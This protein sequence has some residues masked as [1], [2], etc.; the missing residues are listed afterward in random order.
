MKDSFSML[1]T[2]TMSE[3]LI[4]F[5]Q[6]FYKQHD[7][8]PVG[9]PLGPKPV[10]VFLYHE[11]IW[12]QNCSSEFKIGICRRYV[13]DIFLLFRLKHNIKKFW[14]YQMHQHE[15]IRFTS[16]TENKNSIF[17]L[18]IKKSWD[19][20]KFRTSVNCKPKVL[21]TLTAPS[22]SHK[23]NL[24][25]ILLHREFK[26]CSSFRLFH[27]EIDKLRI[28]FKNS[29]YPKSFVDLCVKKILT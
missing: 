4:L 3:S 23:H 29:G 11:K 12:L 9:T 8:V 19:S 1:L 28:I 25:F 6:E 22:Q 24:L 14:N 15:N 10:N 21:P 27:Q 26:Q 20:N 18:D 5:D 2:T 16:E 7:G 13:D 17:F